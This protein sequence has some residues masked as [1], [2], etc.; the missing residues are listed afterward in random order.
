MVASS[1]VRVP[2]SPRTR[3][4]RRPAS[5]PRRRTTSRPQERPALLLTWV[6]TVGMAAAALLG[7]SVPDLYGDPPAIA[8]LM[9]GYDLVTLAGA[10]PL[11][12]LGLVG[13]VR[14]SS[15]GALLRV[16]GSVY[17]LYTY[18]LAA[19]VLGFT[20]V[21]LLHVVI[22]AAALAAVPANLLGPG[23]RPR[24]APWFPR[25]SVAVVLA[26]LALGLGGMWA[27]EAVRAAGGAYEPVG[28][29]LVETGVLVQAGMVL[30]L[31]LLV[32]A[33]VLA[34]VLLWRRSVWAPVTAAAVL[35]SGALHQVSYM[36]ALAFQQSAD[37][38]GATWDTVEPVIAAVFLAATVALLAAAHRPKEPGVERAV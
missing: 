8:S 31:A 37:V 13:P 23:V 34:A 15:R 28:S 38:P 11:L 29:A 19:V 22:L 1:P 35:V 4:P 17:A 9:R 6:V 21:F 33:Y 14:R 27:T 36:V 32:P 2:V 30:D 3:L 10:V 20:P 5:P 18:A 7:L 26:L 12:L 16:G 24:L 25:R